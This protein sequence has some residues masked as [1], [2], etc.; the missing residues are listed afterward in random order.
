MR[1]NQHETCSPASS[2]GAKRIA[3]ESDFLLLFGVTSHDMSST[4]GRHQLGSP[5]RRYPKL[6]AQITA[7]SVGGQLA[8]ESTVQYVG[9]SVSHGTMNGCIF[10][11]R[12]A[13]H[14]AC[15]CRGRMHLVPV[16]TGG[17]AGI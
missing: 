15:V 17:T 12:A 10:S 6:S 8:T 16:L 3:S 1:L 7:A 2:V 9:E 13:L 14:A 4:H 11:W 5:A